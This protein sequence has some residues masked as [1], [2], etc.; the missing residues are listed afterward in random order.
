MFVV[1]INSSGPDIL[2]LMVA[3]GSLVVRLLVGTDGVES[4]VDAPLFRFMVKALDNDIFAICS[5]SESN[6]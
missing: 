6:I 1:E 3:K 5:L 4:V 2:F